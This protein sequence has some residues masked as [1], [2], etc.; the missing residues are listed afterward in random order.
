L[1][2]WYTTKLKP[3][4]RR[5]KNDVINDFCLWTLY[6]PIWEGESD[7]Q[8]SAEKYADVIPKPRVTTDATDQRSIFVDF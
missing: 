7:R 6:G 3:I 1:T 5:N 4:R 2:N 8:F